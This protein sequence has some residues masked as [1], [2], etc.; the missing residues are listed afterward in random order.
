[1]VHTGSSEVAGGAMNQEA[2]CQLIAEEATPLHLKLMISDF[3]S[4]GTLI[5]NIMLL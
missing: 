3:A 2:V 1:M 5:N 4:Q